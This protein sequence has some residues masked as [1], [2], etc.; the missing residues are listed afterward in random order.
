MH[1]AFKKIAATLGLAVAMGFAPST[2]KAIDINPF[3]F[4]VYSLGNIGTSGSPYGSDYQGTAGA[5]GNA[6][7]S[8]F[9]LNDLNATQVVPGF[10]LVTGGDVTIAGQINNGGIQAGGNVVVNHSGIFGD[11][12]AGGNLSGPGGTVHGNVT[13]AGTN[14]ASGS[15]T[16]TGSVTQNTS[17]VGSLNF[18][19]INQYLTDFS[20][21]I[22]SQADTTSYV[23]NYGELVINA[24]SGDN[25][26]TIDGS[27]L[28]S[29]WGVTITGAS[30]SV[31]YINVDGTNVSLDSTNWSYNGGIT[32]GDVLLNFADAS[33]LNLSGGN[34]VNILAALADVN[35][36]YGVVTGNLITGNLTGSGQVN[37]GG[38]EHSVVPEPSSVLALLAGSM[39][40]M[41]RRRKR[42]RAC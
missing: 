29:A 13:L 30:D 19:G 2:A 25:Y 9:S 1:L 11:I 37:L 12:V 21:N 32:A 28:N 15:L 20:A 10:S 34:T 42:N 24:A 31:V 16:I 18:A 8:G 27:T 39:A 41:V 38:F 26:I 4:N 3:D 33:T 17:Y 6:Y 35:F 36:S 7:F 23:N 5:A 14:N 40:M 22:G